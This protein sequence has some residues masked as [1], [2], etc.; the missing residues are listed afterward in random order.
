MSTEY[1]ERKNIISTK[2]SIMIKI[3]EDYII[4][5]MDVV[6]CENGHCLKVLDVNTI[7]DLNIKKDVLCIGGIN[8]ESF[9][10]LT[11]II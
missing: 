6:F 3:L 9:A 8:N 11:M 4:N 1:D 5:N 10:F 2:I 7:F